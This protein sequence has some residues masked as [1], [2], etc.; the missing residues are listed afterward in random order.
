MLDLT[1]IGN[2]EKEVMFELWTMLFLMVELLYKHISK[3]RVGLMAIT[4]LHLNLSTQYEANIQYS[5]LKQNKMF[6]H[7]DGLPFN[8]SKGDLLRNSKL[9]KN[10]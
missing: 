7:S 3:E 1:S 2:C 9:N 4:S 5:F 8:V 6:S 10:L